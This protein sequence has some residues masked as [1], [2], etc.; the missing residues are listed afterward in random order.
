[1]TKEYPKGEV[2]KLTTAEYFTSSGEKIN[3]IGV[4]PD[5]FI[6]DRRI[7][8]KDLILHKTYDYLM[9]ITDG[10]EYERSI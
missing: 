6:E 9:L 8:D 10:G 5:I 7:D 4:S 2:L 1:M 3:N